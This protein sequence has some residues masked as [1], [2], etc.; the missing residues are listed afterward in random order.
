MSKV[1]EVILYSYWRSSCSWRVRTALA[2]KNLP[3]QYKAVHLVK[4]EQLNSDYNSLNPSAQVPTLIINGKTLTQSLPIMEYLEDAYRFQGRRLLPD[5]QED[6]Y[7]VRQICEIINSG[8]QPIQNLDVMKQLGKYFEKY[9]PKQNLKQ[10]ELQDIKNIWAKDAII[11]GF[12]SLETVLIKTGGKYCVG[13][14]VSMADCCLVPQVYNA[15]RFGV[16][17]NDYPTISK[18]YNNCIKLKE[19]QVSHPDQQPDVQ[20]SKL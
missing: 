7:R 18:I 13:N 15:E 1:S 12:K 11:K 2:F 20:K 3:Y 5:C 10:E 17:L 19:F 8:I 6:K 16:N 9:A 4:G 14:D